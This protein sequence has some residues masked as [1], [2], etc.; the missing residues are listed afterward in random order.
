MEDVVLQTNFDHRW[1][2]TAENP[3]QMVA[4]WIFYNYL[5]NGIQWKVKP[6]YLN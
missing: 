6:N 4:I 3:V 5:F 1:E 2:E